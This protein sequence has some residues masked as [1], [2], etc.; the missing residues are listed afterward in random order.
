MYVCGHACLRMGTR[1]VVSNPLCTLLHTCCCP[2]VPCDSSSKACPPTWELQGGQP[3]GSL[4]NS[5][6]TCPVIVVSHLTF[7]VTTLYLGGSLVPVEKSGSGVYVLV[8]GHWEISHEDE[9]R[10]GSE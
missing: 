3:E 2:R 8:G 7:D 5:H 9:L 10:E 6:M 4:Q 1:M